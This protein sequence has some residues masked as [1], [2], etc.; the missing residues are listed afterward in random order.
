MCRIAS[1]DNVVGLSVTD[2]IGSP[3]ADRNATESQTTSTAASSGHV[4]SRKRRVLFSKAQTR[5]L[6]RR[7][8]D[9]RYL[10]AAERDELAAAL[11]LSPLQIKIWFQNHRYKLKKSQHERRLRLQHAGNVAIGRQYRH[12]A[13]DTHLQASY[14]TTVQCLCKL[15]RLGSDGVLVRSNPSI[16]IR[17]QPARS[18]KHKIGKQTERLGLCDDDR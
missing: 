11:R 3:V 2:D 1:D 9:Q 16:S 15:I 5:E 10:S 13:A 7:F 8:T 6:E 4:T 17:Q 14:F 18:I 12:A